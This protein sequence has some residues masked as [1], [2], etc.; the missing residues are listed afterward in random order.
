MLTSRIGTQNLW[1]DVS[2]V[3]F[4][5]YDLS[6]ERDRFC[7]GRLVDLAVLEPGENMCYE[8]F[9]ER[10]FQCPAS[11]SNDDIPKK[12]TFSVYYCRSDRVISGII[13]RCPSTS[14]PPNFTALQPSG[15]EW[16]ELHKRNRLRS[17]IRDRFP[18]PKMAFLVMDESGDGSLTRKEFARGMRL[19]GVELKAHEMANLMELL[20]DD[21]GGEIDSEE[22][23]AFVNATD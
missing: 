5:E 23:V 19:I 13:A 10:E 12:G 2:A 22:F 14:I 11:W 3:R 15:Q 6:N 7:A 9:N 4:H 18:D 1:D 17:L 8:H 16:V 21:G 20:D